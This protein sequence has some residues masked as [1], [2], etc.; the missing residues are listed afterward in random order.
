MKAVSHSGVSSCIREAAHKPAEFES[1][2]RRV[3]HG[4]NTC[5]ENAP[6]WKKNMYIGCPYACLTPAYSPHTI[7]LWENY[8]IAPVYRSYTMFGKSTRGLSIIASQE[9]HLQTRKNNRN[10]NKINS[11]LEGKLVI[12]HVFWIILEVKWKSNSLGRPFFQYLL[13]QG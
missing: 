9:S 4:W 6:V 12:V 5:T 13:R 3:K 10:L 2:Y 11:T 1:H 7:A 8:L